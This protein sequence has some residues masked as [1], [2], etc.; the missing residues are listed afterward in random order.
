ME[1]TRSMLAVNIAAKLPSPLAL[2][3]LVTALAAG[4]VTDQL[5]RATPWGLNLTLSVGAVV[6]AALI[7]TR[8]GSV[9]LEGEGRWLVVPLLF[10]AGA[11]A[12]RDSPTLNV[13]N[14]VALVV[15]ATLAALTSRA[16]QVRLAGI[17]QY[18]LGIAYVLAYAGVGLLPTRGEL[19]WRRWR[20]RWW[21]APALAAGRGVVLAI[22]P[23][24]VFGGLFMAADANFEKLVRNAFEVDLRDILG[25]LGLIGVCA[26]LIGGTLHEMLLVP[27]RPRHWLDRPSRLGLG[28]VEV[29]VI[30]GLVDLLFLVFVIVQLPYLFGGI[31]Q[32]AQLGY[33]EYTRRGFFE[34]VWVAGLTLPLLLWAHWL[35]RG[36]GRAGQRAYRVLA[37]G[38]VCLLCVVMASAVQRMQLYVE[39]SG[40]TELRVQASVFMGWLAVVLGWFVVTVLRGDR[41]RFAF[42]AL[43]SAFVVIGGL[44]VAN[45]DA[46]I[47]RTN[48]H[49]GHLEFEAPLDARPLAS[50]SADATPAIVAALPLLSP[51]AQGT[52]LATLKSRLGSAVDGPSDW[53]T[54][55]WS[56]AQARAAVSQL[57]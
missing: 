4:V 53:R 47:V 15:A 50:F 24:V 33:S 41:R 56:R 3:V 55:N 10:F 30:V 19:V 38:L 16:G 13:A 42:G 57:H 35:V 20:W 9:E 28:S 7:V 1:Q 23:L 48:A 52:V 8:W 37:L 26:W 39:S 40:L 14:V 18:A 17:T 21:S 44:D 11:V 51:E 27:L 43:V 25:H 6:L 34:L 31:A 29:S 46:L 32:V 12:W 2:R 54:F 45:P 36:S 22:P 49:Y 5:L